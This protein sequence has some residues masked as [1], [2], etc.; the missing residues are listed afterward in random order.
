L[1]GLVS[2]IRS[3]LGLKKCPEKTRNGHARQSD[4]S[5]HYEFG[6]V[7][8]FQTKQVT[9]DFSNDFEAMRKLIG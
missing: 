5:K 3:R 4:Y 9:E 6:K 8:P 1:N 2:P 7:I